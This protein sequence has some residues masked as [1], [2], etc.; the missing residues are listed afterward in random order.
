MT[1]KY[2]YLC[3]SFCAHNLEIKKVISKKQQGSNFF[4][5]KSKY[6]HAQIKVDDF[7]VAVILAI[8]SIVIVW[9]NW[10]CFKS[11]EYDRIPCVPSD[12][13]SRSI[14]LFY[15]K[16]PQ[17]VSAVSAIAPDRVV[18]T[19]FIGMSNGIVRFLVGTRLHLKNKL[20]FFFLNV[21]G[22]D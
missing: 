11:V 15:V 17:T 21:S 6:T 13:K 3:Q 10:D 7:F 20:F 14:R 19:V 12:F 5:F 22:T 8:S 4:L 18:W 2:S 9:T 16:T 1:N